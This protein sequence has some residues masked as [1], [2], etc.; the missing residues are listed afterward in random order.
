[1]G[2]SVDP[3]LSSESAWSVGP[4][5]TYALKNVSSLDHEPSRGPSSIYMHFY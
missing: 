3:L 4:I 2:I 5:P 1:M